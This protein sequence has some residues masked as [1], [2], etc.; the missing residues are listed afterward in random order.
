MVLPSSRPDRGL[1]E[2]A[3]K[4]RRLA[5]VEDDR[6]PTLRSRCLHEAGSEGRHAGEVTEQVERH[7]FPGQER[8]RG[9]GDQRDLTRHRFGPGSF[10]DELVEIAGAGQPER[11]GRDVETEDDAGSFWKIF[12]RARASAG[13]VASVVTSP[14]PRSSASARATSSVVAPPGPLTPG[15]DRRR[16]SGQELAHEAVEIAVEHPL[17][18][19]GLVPGPIVLDAGCR[20]KRVAADLRAPARPPSARR[21]PPRA[22]PLPLALLLGDQPRPEHLHGR[23]LVLGLGALVLAL[24]DDAGRN[25]GQADRRVRLVD[26]LSPGARGTVGVDPDVGL[27]ELDVDVVGD[28]RRDL[29]LCERRVAAGLRVRG[30]IRTYRMIAALGG[31]SP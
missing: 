18:V 2:R 31:D 19:A 5:G 8:S 29:E 17:R 23:C 12:A 7:A 15:P 4:R 22:P 1:L 25:M 26:V 10:D 28:E 20:V 16:R 14:S 21:V 3:K 9:A 30:E 24:H 11:L 27:V 6:R 13:T